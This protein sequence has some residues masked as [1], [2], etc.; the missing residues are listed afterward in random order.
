MMSDILHQFKS[1]C[2]VVGPGLTVLHANDMARTCF[3]RPNRPPGALDFNDLPQMIGSKVFEVLKTGANLAD[4]RYQP[5]GA[6]GQHYQITITP[7]RS[8]NPR[9][10]PRCCW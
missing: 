5:A 10:R 1:G 6:P 8:D 3:P 4:L 9:R 7:F 2:V